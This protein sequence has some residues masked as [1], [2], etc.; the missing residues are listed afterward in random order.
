M[1]KGLGFEEHTRRN[2]WKATANAVT[3]PPEAGTITIADRPAH[4]WS[5]QLAWLDQLHPEELAWYRSWNWKALK[6]GLWN[7]LYRAFVEFEQRQW[8]AFASDKLQ[9]VLSWIPNFRR[10]L[11]WLACDPA[12]DSEAITSLL[13]HVRREFGYQRKLALEHPCNV[14]DEAIQGAG[15][16]LTRSLVWMRIPGATR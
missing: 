8:A 12:S 4:L 1:Y 11:L 2:S 14:K 3:R 6:P 16:E 5:Q 13:L 7:W 9:G 15:F 10:D